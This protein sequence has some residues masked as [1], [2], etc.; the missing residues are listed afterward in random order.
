MIAKWLLLAAIL[1]AGLFLA[2]GEIEV[3][4]SQH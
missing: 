3:F 2:T 1:A 4:P